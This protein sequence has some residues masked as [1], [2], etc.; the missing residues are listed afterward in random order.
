MR[1]YRQIHSLLQEAEQTALEMLSLANLTLCYAA[2]D[3]Q[4]LRK[5]RIL[6]QQSERTHS[7]NAA[8]H[9]TG[10]IRW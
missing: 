9:A 10:K 5:H 8:R 1:F 6:S 3:R 2:A 4:R 7:W